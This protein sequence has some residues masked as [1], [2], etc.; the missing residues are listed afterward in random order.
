MNFIEYP[1]QELMMADVARLL[2]DDLVSALEHEERISFAVP[3]G[4]TPGPLFDVL[5]SVTLPWER[6]S[7]L[8]TDERWVPEDDPRSNARLIR[9]RLLTGKAAAASFVSLHADTETPE[10]ALGALAARVEPLRPISVLLLGMGE[11]MHVASLIPGG[12][13]LALALSKAA[14]PV[15]AIRAPGVP[16]PR[17][18]LS[19]PVLD[20]ALAKHLLITGK[21]K[22]E[23]LER[24]RHLPPEEAPV[25]AVM[26]ELTVHWA[27]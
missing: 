7:V 21:A 14:P 17:V 25:R 10:E 5:A 27:P 24:A 6:V 15:V 8:P 22:R 3:G 12:D 4:S 26:H 23:A 11:D 20:G 1:D 18:T 16:E 19:A 9:E 13:K 2:T